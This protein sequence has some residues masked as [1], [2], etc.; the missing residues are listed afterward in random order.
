MAKAPTVTNPRIA[1][2]IEL[3]VSGRIKP[4]HQRE[5]DTYR[6]RGLAPKSAASTEG[7]RKASAFLTRALGA[8]KQYESTGVGPRSLVGQGLADNAPNLLNSLPGSVGNSSARQ[9]AD[10]AQD[11]FIA[12]SLRQDSGA[13]I[14]DDELDRQRR[15]YFPMP[16]DGPEVIEAKRAARARAIQGLVESAGSG[17][18]PKLRDQ[19]PEYFG[20]KP[21]A[22]SA[23]AAPAKPIPVEEYDAMMG[24]M[25]REGAT[26]EQI[27][28]ASLKAGYTITNPEVI[29]AAL[30]AGRVKMDTKG[31]DTS[32]RGGPLA[33]VDATARGAADT[34]T[35]GL[36]DEIAAGVNTFLPLD[37]LVGNDQIVSIWDGLSPQDAYARNLELQR[38]VDAADEKNRPVSRFAGQ[39]AGG[40]VGGTGLAKAVPGASTILTSG[41]KAARV[42]KTSALAAFGGGAYGGG[43]APEGERVTNALTGAA[44]APVAGFLGSQAAK[45]LGGFLAPVVDPAIARLRDAGV[46]LTPGQAMGGAFNRAEAKL[47]ALPVVGDM[48]RSGRRRSI[49]TFNDAAFNEALAPIGANLPKGTRGTKAHA[50]AQQRFDEAYDDAR[51]GMRLEIDDQLRAD[52]TDLAQ[53]VAG[54]EL[55]EPSARRLQAVIKNTLDRRLTSGGT[56]GDG[57]KKIVSEL[58]R[59]ARK[60]RQGD[61][62]FSAAV[63]DLQSIIDA[64]A[65]RVSDPEAVAK[66]AKAD[67]GYAKFVRIEGAAARAGGGPGTFTPAQFSREVQKQSGSVRSR[68]YLR[69]DAMMQDLADAGLDV[70]PENIPDSG[71]PERL[72][73]NLGVLGGGAAISPVGAATYG[74]LGVPYAPGVRDAVTYALIGR[75][76]AAIERAGEAFQRNALLGYVAAPL[77]VGALTSR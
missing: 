70:L 40:L 20:G 19:Y 1:K 18:D 14:P 12:A 77:A 22:A 61:P 7:E 11:E 37:R 30:A 35:F 63:T 66:L 62:E 34:L 60:S 69:G 2:L 52:M 45:T 29:P 55:A 25:I 48:I 51:S 16:G 27:T 5:L 57:Y 26:P 44:V 46:K 13:A 73:L 38:G 67:E 32:G 58:G 59:V 31:P 76:P 54:G 3:E 10:T 49:E 15:I 33:S 36:A 43:S 72:A 39:F 41:S 6:A 21:A 23:A 50:F 53:R 56:D 4:E 8:N 71:T 24:R 64:A 74:A 42:A 28:E 47:Q 65:R 9:V 68:E 75:R 17:L